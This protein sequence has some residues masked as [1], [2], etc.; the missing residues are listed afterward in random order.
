MAIDKAVDS[1]ILDGYFEDIADAI[2]EKTGGS[3]TYTPA[4]MSTAIENLPSGGGADLDEY[5]EDTI[6]AGD[7]SIPGFSKAIKKFKSPLTI[8]GTSLTY[9]FRYYKGTE[10]PR[11]NGD[12]SAITNMSFMF[13][14]C[15]NLTNLNLS[16]F[17]TSNVTNMRDMFYNCES[18]TTLNLSNF[19]TSKVTTMWHMFH[20][21]SNL[22]SLDLSNFDTSNVVEMEEMFYGCESLPALN[23]SSFNTSKLTSMKSMFRGCKNLT[24]LD[25]SNFDMSK[26]GSTVYL[27]DGCENLTNL[28][29]PSTVPT[30]LGSM[31]YTFMNCKSLVDLDLSNFDMSKITIIGDILKGCTSLTNLTFGTDLGAGYSTGAASSYNN[32]TLNLSTCTSLTHDSLMSVIN[33]IYD[34]ASKGVKKQKL[35][36]G[37]ANLEKL[38]AEEI[39]IATDKGWN[40]S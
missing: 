2:R 20:G 38:T 18:L 26:I 31:Q 28:I 35:V 15:T 36:L 3:D 13:S 34:L 25:L 17:N 30:N 1:S 37:S 11:L 10:I 40:V 39:A 33:N 22:T 23:L 5:F 8:T 29:L 27:F 21:C 16:Y 12:M 32:Y 6:T 4:Q 14:Y 19:N 7:S 24:S 9:A